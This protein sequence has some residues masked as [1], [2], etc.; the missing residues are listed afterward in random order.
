MNSP[1]EHFEAPITATEGALR[2][3]SGIVRGLQQQGYEKAAPEYLRLSRLLANARRNELLRGVVGEAPHW[4]QIRKLAAEA[5]RLLRPLLES[6]ET[7]A[8]LPISV[9]PATA[10]AD[11]VQPRRSAHADVEP[12]TGVG[13]KKGLPKAAVSRNSNSK[14]KAAEKKRTPE[15]TQ[16]NSQSPRRRTRSRPAVARRKPPSG[17]AAARA[18]RPTP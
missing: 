6:A 18:K 11:E 7:L 4:I 12:S 8:N 3:W 14:H 1:N 15:S 2:L 5:A 9:S 16:K 17:K 13:P 10:R